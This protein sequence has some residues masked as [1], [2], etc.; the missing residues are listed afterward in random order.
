MKPITFLAFIEEGSD[1]LIVGSQ[2]DPLFL[3]EKF[4]IRIQ[5]EFFEIKEINKK[6]KW[7]QFKTVKSPDEKSYIYIKDLNEKE[8]YKKD[9]LEIH[10]KEHKINGAFSIPAP[11]SGYKQN[12]EIKILGFGGA[13]L[14]LVE[15]VNKDGGVARAKIKTESSFFQEGY[16]S[17]T[18]EGGSGEGLEIVCEMIENNKRTIIEKTAKE[19]LFKEKRNYIDFEYN[20]PDFVKKGEIKIHRTEITLG[21]KCKDNLLGGFICIAQKVDY[22]EKLGIPVVEKGTINAYNLYNQ[23]S[24]IVEKK[25]LELEKR[26][27]QLES[28]I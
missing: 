18:P 3:T 4:S 1:K 22:T 26:I 16:K 9:Y 11:G 20:L 13:G 5:D 17:F 14:V 27:D 24:A 15:E 2:K 6:E 23:G 21:K 10:L 28:R 7:L 12:D 19:P 8:I 25:I